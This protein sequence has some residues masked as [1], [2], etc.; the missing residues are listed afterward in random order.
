M[1]EL[2]IVILTNFGLFCQILCD[3]R[4]CQF[5][6]SLIS[7]TGDMNLQ[8]NLTYFLSLKN[9]QHLFSFSNNFFTLTVGK[10]PEGT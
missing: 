5:P 1:M 10:F 3:F 9:V 4:K 7:K 6:S 8:K 2:F